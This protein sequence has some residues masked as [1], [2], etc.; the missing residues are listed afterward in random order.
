[1]KSFF[2]YRQATFWEDLLQRSAYKTLNQTDITERIYNV[3]KQGINNL[4]SY[5]K[6]DYR[7][8][9][10]EVLKAGNYQSINQTFQ[11]ETIDLYKVGIE[12]DLKATIKDPVTLAKAQRYTDDFFAELKGTAT[13]ADLK[14][15]GQKFGVLEPEGNLSIISYLI[16]KTDEGVYG[17]WDI[18]WKTY[19][20]S[21]KAFKNNI[22]I[23]GVIFDR[24]LNLWK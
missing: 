2:Y 24:A 21:D 9:R 15:F 4:T 8:L 11:I 10:E 20:K 1:M 17:Y 7:V 23:I 3:L 14:A 19:A 13:D 18:F 16:K 6:V 12:K 5:K 22:R